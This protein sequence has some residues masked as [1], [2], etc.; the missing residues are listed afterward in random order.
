MP[1]AG[2]SSDNFTAELDAV[3]DTESESGN[4]EREDEFDAQSD[5]DTLRMI[6]TI[7]QPDAPMHEVRR[8]LEVA[9]QAYTVVRSELR[10]LKKDHA[11]LQAA[12]PARSQNRALKKTSMVDN[13]IT[14]AGKMYAMLNYFW[15]MSGLFP[16]IPQPNIDPHS[17]T[18]WSSPEAKLNGAMAEL[19]QCI[20]KALHKSMETYPQFGLVFCAVV[21]SERSNILHSLKDCAG[22]IFSGLKLDPTVFTDEPAKKKENEQLLALLKKD[23]GGEK[24]T[25]LAP[26]LFTDPSALVPDDFL[27][28]SVM[29]KIIR[30]EIF[31]KA[32]LSGKTKGHLKARGQCWSTQCVTEGL[33]AGAAIVA[34]FLLTHDQELTAT[35]PAT[36]IDYAQDF[37]FYLERLFKR[38]PW[39]TSVI[40]YY[41]KEI[42]GTSSVLATSSTPA[43]SSASQPRTWEDDF[44]QQLEDPASVPQTVPV[45]APQL[46]TSSHITYAPTSASRADINAVTTVNYQTA[47][48]IMDIGQLS[49]D[50]ARPDSAPSASKGGRVS[51]AHRR[52]TAQSAQI[53]VDS[54]MVPIIPLGP[55]PAAKRVTR[56]GGVKPKKSGKK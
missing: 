10:A 9:Q 31:G 26:I 38:S 1:Q 54:D 2:D 52:A 40:N 22:L 41:N 29:V 20:P 34:R 21:S 14:H 27:K 19:Y 43:P 4:D 28:T 7:P 5:L 18:R 32:S 3:E 47:M 36:K 16:T 17:D 44:L 24:Y 49:L 8:V 23:V 33:I 15:V 51:A 46:P 50:G 30:V 11:M 6:L 13:D 55:P 35:G 12:I 45:P 39:A 25:R 48:S 56:N 42:F 37:D 53:T